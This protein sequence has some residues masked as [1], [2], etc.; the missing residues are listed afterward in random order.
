MD[1]APSVFDPP[2]RAWHRVSP[3]LAPL[4]RLSAAIGVAVSTLAAALGLWFGLRLWWPAAI[5]V[6]AG[7]LLYAWLAWRAGRWVASW[8][9]AERDGD[10]CIRHGLMWR[11]L[12]VVPFARMQLVKVSS[13]P[14]QRAFGLSTVE[15]VTASAATGATIPGL[16]T[17]D[18]VAL[19]DRL[20]GAS[21]ALGSGL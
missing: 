6:G 21:D 18:A 8:G 11:T 13:G 20:I 5:A 19:R 16:P 7:L 3:R 1:A 17:A 15:L 9:W 12:V 10:L 2:A 4:K 14:L